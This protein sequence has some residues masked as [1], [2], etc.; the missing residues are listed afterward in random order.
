MESPSSGVVVVRKGNL[1]DS[2]A[3]T[4]GMPAGSR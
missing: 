2:T 4:S 1:S 3:Q